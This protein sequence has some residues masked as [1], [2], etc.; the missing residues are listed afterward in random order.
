MWSLSSLSSTSYFVI[1]GMWSR[2]NCVNDHNVNK[3][4]DDE[5]LLNMLCKCNVIDCLNII[6]CSQFCE[7]NRPY[8]LNFVL[9]SAALHMLVQSACSPPPSLSSMEKLSPTWSWREKRGHSSQ[10]EGLV[11]LHSQLCFFIFHHHGSILKLVIVTFAN[12]ILSDNSYLDF[13]FFTVTKKG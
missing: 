3:E 1:R 11:L 6:Q 9:H 7:A 12:T 5:P 2:S 4:T 10:H 8:Y 13:A